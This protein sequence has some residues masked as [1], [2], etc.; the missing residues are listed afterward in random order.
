MLSLSS[1]HA[2]Q[3]ALSARLILWRY[4]LSRKCCRR[5]WAIW[6]APFLVSFA[7]LIV[8]RNLTDGVVLS[9]CFAFFSLAVCLQLSAQ[10]F[11]SLSLWSLLN[12]DGLL[13]RG[14]LRYGAEDWLERRNYSPLFWLLCLLSHFL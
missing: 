5:S 14:F 6:L 1:P 3:F 9:M 11:F 4:P 10:A 2:G 7:L 8:L 13:Q 12:A